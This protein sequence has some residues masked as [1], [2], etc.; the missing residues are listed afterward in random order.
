MENPSMENQIEKEF[1]D[2]KLNHPTYSGWTIYGPYQRKEDL[3]RHVVAYDGINRVTISYPR[4]IL[5]CKLRRILN[6]NEEVHHKNEIEFHDILENLEVVNST[7]HRKN[8]NT[9]EVEFFT[10]PQC[11]NLFSMEGLRLSR[12][13]SER[14]RRP[15]L[16][17]PYCSKSCSGKAG[18]K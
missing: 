8:H 3:R 15:D 16:R 17:G 7:E 4:F 12:M 6:E 5:E 11:N 9:N 2:N 1:Q 13:K 18:K 10:C 14:R